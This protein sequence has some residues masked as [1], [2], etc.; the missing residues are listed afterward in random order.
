MPP[1]T[2]QWVI[3]CRPERA[4]AIQAASPFDLVVGPP[5]DD[6]S[7]P[8]FEQVQGELVGLYRTGAKKDKDTIEKDRKKYFRSIPPAELI[9]T[10]RTRVFIRTI[11]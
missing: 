11:F 1:Q 4:D 9:D 8:E 3:N 6:G 2:A 10:S 5:H 7:A